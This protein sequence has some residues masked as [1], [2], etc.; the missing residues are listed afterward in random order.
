MNAEKVPMFDTRS[1]KTDNAPK[2]GRAESAK[3]FRSAQRAWTAVEVSKLHRLRSQGLARPAV[4]AQ[5]GRTVG[6]VK[7]MMNRI[8]DGMIA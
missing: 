5:L 7:G 2:E 1:A 6:S 8:A 4:A 3:T